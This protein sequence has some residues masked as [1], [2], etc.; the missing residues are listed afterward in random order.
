MADCYAMNVVS[1]DDV[2][3]NYYMEFPLVHIVN[4]VLEKVVLEFG[5]LGNEFAL[6]DDHVLYVNKGNIL[7]QSI[8]SSASPEPVE[9]CDQSGHRL[10]PIVDPHAGFVGRGSAALLNTGTAIYGLA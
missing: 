3:L 5:C 8:A 7:M 4:G 10:I 6:R 9:A 1:S 2:W